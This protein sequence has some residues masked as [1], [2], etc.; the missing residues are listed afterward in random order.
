MNDNSKTK[1]QLIK[2]LADIRRR[3]VELEESEAGRKRHDAPLRESEEI[4]RSLM[5]QMT[6][7]IIIIDWDG[8]IRFANAAALKLVGV[9]LSTEAL[10]KNIAEFIDPDTL[11]EVMDGFVM[12]RTGQKGVIRECKIIAADRQE[13]WVE[14]IGTKVHFQGSDCNM[15][16]I[17]DITG[18][19]RVEEAL[20]K[21]E[22][23]YRFITEKMADMVWTVDMDLHTTYVSPSILNVLGFTP[24]ERMHQT[25]SEIMPPG[26]LERVVQ[27][28]KMEMDRDQ[29]AGVDPNRSITLEV[30]YYHK[31]GSVIC[32][33]NVMG[34][35]RDDQGNLIG[36]HGL[37]RDIT[38]RKKAEEALRESEE[39]HRILLSES[40]DPIFSFTPDG[41]YQYVNRAFANGVGKSP[42]DIIGKKIWDVFPREEADKRF[43]S[44][45][46]AFHT[47]KE[48]VI[49]V[50]VPRPDGARYYVTT[51][52]P[53]K[54]S[55][56]DVLSVICSSKEITGRKRAEDA[57]RESEEKFRVL[58]DSTPT[59]VMLFQDGRYVYANHATE[60]ISGYSVKELLGMNFWDVIHPD[61]QAI[62][63]E[64]VQ[65]RLRGEATVNRYEIKII[66]KKGQEKWV[67]LSGASTMMGG[68]P[69]GIVSFVDITDRK[70]AEEALKA[71]E[72]KYRKIFEGATEGIY[73]TTPEGRY[74]SMNPAFAKMFGYASPR[75]MIESITNIGQQ[76][77]VNPHDREEMTRRLREHNKVDGYEVEV[78]RKDGSRFWISINIHTVRDTAGNILYFEGM[79][80]DITERKKTEE[81]LRVSEE[82][83]RHSEQFLRLITDNVQDAIR[84]MDLQ[85]L[86]Y[87]YANSYCYKIF[88]I[89][90][91]NYIN[92]E[93]GINL[94]KEEK[95]RLFE[96]FQDEFEHDQERD[97]NRYRSFLL[98]ET[99]KLTGE[100]IWTENKAS[101][102]R[103]ADGRPTAV[104]SI[105]RD[106]TARKRLEEERLKLQERLGRSEKMEAIGTLAGGVAHD[107][108][109]VLGVL[110]GYSELMLENIPGES[111]LKK[112]VTNILQ[113][114]QRGAAIVQDLLTLARRGV[115]IVEVVNLNQSVA[116]Y[117]ITPEFENVKAYHPLVVFKTD[118]AQD[119]LNI[120]GSP[121]HLGKTIM[122]LVSNA[123][124]A[125]SGE[126]EVVIRT[127]NR[128]LD[129]P[130]LGYDDMQE[131]EYA[132]LSVSD[133]GQGIAQQDIGKI[134]EPFYTKKVMGRSGTGL[135]LAVVWGTVKDHNGHIDVQSEQG[136]GTTFTLYFPVTREEP[137]KIVQAVSPDFYMGK[138][139]FILVVDD[140]K[141]Q[142]ELAMSILERL[143][144]RTDAVA[145][146][147]MAIEYIKKK[148]ADLIVLDMIMGSGMDGTETYRQI[149]EIHSGQKAVI[150][151]GFSETNRVRKAQEMGAGAFVR[152]PYI[153]EKLGLAIRKELDRTSIGVG[154]RP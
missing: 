139:E 150:V 123:A 12:V 97:P 14:T 36:V 93:L 86:K 37:S 91:Q 61:Y 52:T 122:N 15:V 115:A 121:I 126:G 78:Y 59:A 154:G 56:G 89:T 26:S 136:K 83:Y 102:I 66:T 88:G 18:R 32:C 148:K 127:E 145:S 48:K 90:P 17:R 101:F 43:V 144:Y 34:T 65:K 11:P 129:Q 53:V 22:K 134:F 67:E 147:E 30:E 74:L 99:N 120:K 1:Q 58:A 116:G 124:E 82:K 51:I 31:D 60:T 10:G 109:N 128:Y 81:S 114:G 41:Q 69:A 38:R 13:K 118:L 16:N 62:T 77:Y 72:E 21:S 54:N 9:D 138:G 96:I 80:V 68:K 87:T 152:K 35:V 119:L 105:T 106:I 76:L 125:I 133:N 25:V 111:P 84:L 141:E 57:L 2:E 49:E 20:L 40:T 5:D 107:L 19:K 42:E 70:I 79:N 146:G 140:V 108:N 73:Q 27:A 103:N 110:V 95:Q 45:N 64:H 33:E 149:L 63:Q 28:L 71:S 142:R 94:G 112:Y 3:L 113:S 85:T 131:G 151:S 75:D 130:I 46:E 98:R 117:L 100:T 50:R 92:A 24:E 153:I 47:G 29:K 39:R 135:G 7:S 4:L 8:T 44:L 104:I 143:G 137:G 55:K 132:V 23:K 6:D